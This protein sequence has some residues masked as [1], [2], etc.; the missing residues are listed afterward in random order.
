MAEDAVVG[1]LRVVLGLDTA[2]FEEGVKKATVSIGSFA[3]SVTRIASGVGLGL[4]LAKGIESFVH[5]VVEG[6]ERIDKAGK[7]AQK[8]GLPV[9]EFTKLGFAAQ[10]SDVSMETLSKSLGVLSKNMVAAAQGTGEA[11]KTFQALG[12][13]VRNSDG[14]L[15]SASKVLEEISGKFEKSSDGAAKTAAAL[16]LL[17]RGGKDLI[18][19]LNEGQASLQELG[20]T[21][22]KMGL[23]I[24]QKTAAQVQSFN[25]NIKILAL[26][27]EGFVNM[28]I[29]GVIPALDNLAKQFVVTAKE[30]NA[31]RSMADAVTKGFKEFLVLIYQVIAADQILGRAFNELQATIGAFGSAIGTLVRGVFQGVINWVSDL[32]SRITNFVAPALNLIGTLFSTI[33]AKIVAF[34]G[35]AVTLLSELWKLIKDNLLP[36]VEEFSTKFLDTSGFEAMFK[37]W[38][39]LKKVLGELSPALAEAIAKVEELFKNLGGTAK[40]TTDDISTGVDRVAQTINDFALRTRILRGEFSQLAVGFAEQAVRLKL[41]DE[42]AKG[43]STTMQ[44]LTPQQLLLNDAML[45]FRA[46]QLTQES[47]APYEQYAQKMREIALLQDQAGL[48]SERA[49]ILMRQ[50][51]ESTSQ[52]WDVAG[53]KI[54]GDLASGLKAF[55]SQNKAFAVA[56]KAAA[57]VQAIINT[58][59][60]AT[61]ALAIYGPTPIGFAASAAAIVAGLGH[62]ATIRAQNFATGGSFRVGGGMTG[63]DSEMVSFAATPGEIVDVRRPGTRGERTGGGVQTIELRSPRVRDFFSENVRDLVDVLNKAAP[64]GYILKVS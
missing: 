32:G 14:S 16:Q 15:K 28:V 52:A 44:G 31:A 40:K 63:V 35:P 4:A 10:L 39:N 47:L 48:S 12:I 3:A 62:V 60:A 9:E 43:L 64:D 58:Y 7:E 21:A 11:Q 24:S 49:A 19:L 59:T 22:E 46:A 55:A 36:T 13:T 8:I 30:G 6:F 54:A 18:P 53:S 41:T 38:E 57:I 29:E 23:V 25:D 37:H 26:S 56:G 45:K 2:K 17:G 50:A 51:A 33:A 1:A 5:Q 34:L 20:V 27:K 61:K 42:A